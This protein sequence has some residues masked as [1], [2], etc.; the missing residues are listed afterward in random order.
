VH[1]FI[2]RAAALI[3]LMLAMLLASGFITPGTARAA[4]SFLPPVSYTKTGAS[5]I[6]AVDLDADGNLDL[7]VGDVN[8][9][10]LSLLY[11]RGDGTF[12]PPVDMLLGNSYDVALGTDH[13]FIGADVNGDGLPDLIVPH[14]ASGKVLVFLNQGARTFAPPVS[15]PVGAVPVAF[16]AADFNGDGKLDLAVSNDGPNTLSVLLN[17][18]DGTF[19]PADSYPTGSLPGGVSAAD[20]DGDGRLDLAVANIIGGTVTVYFGD[21]AGK[22]LPGGTYPA[23]GGAGH[24]VIADFD[25][26]GAL[27]IA[28]CNWQDSSVSVLLGNGNGAFKPTLYYPAGGNAGVMGYADFDGDGAPDLA[29]ARGHTDLVT[30]LHNNGAGIFDSPLQFPSGG[31]NTR[32]LAVGD[33]NNDGRPDIAAGGQD[34]YT[35]SILINNTPRPAL[36]IRGLTLSSSSAVAGC[37]VTHGVVTLT[38]PAPAGGT[39]IVL[40]SSNPAVMVPA[41]VPVPEGATQTTFTPMVSPVTTTVVGTITASLPGSVQRAPFTVRPGGMALLKLAPAALIGGGSVSGEVDLVCPAGPQGATVVL[42]SSRPDL[43]PA[44]AV[45]IVPPGGTRV[46]F[47]LPTQR[48]SAD[49]AVTLTATFDGFTRT[50]KVELHPVP[51]PPPPPPPVNLLVNGSFEDPDTSGSSIGWLTYGAAGIPGRAPAGA[52]IPG[53]KITQGTVDVTSWYWKAA[54]GR[55]S[56]DLVGDNPGAF[57]QSFATEPGKEY[58]FSGV[59]AHNPGNFFLAEGRGNVF[60]NHLFLTQLVHQDEQA[61]VSDMHW[62][63]FS[64][65]F[66]ATSATTTLT[67]SDATGTPFPGG[68]VLDGLAVTPTGG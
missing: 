51:P 30:V 39:A 54:V 26:D 36:A 11:G 21:G 29:C 38:S 14:W 32:T 61:T 67:I 1:R 65:R 3:S 16:T 68:L 47:S 17:R 23:G 25:G 43:L 40:T 64:V 66:R 59:I 13:Q 15:Y 37:D 57:E 19:Q 2:R 7:I 58:S 50:A 60:V 41:S 20:L 9:P 12:E 49:T 45:V 42:A 33:F 5:G 8:G 48:V 53:W 35:V 55:Q 62:T 24:V 10:R 56:L 18:G 6:T 52:S 46:S 44:P 27:D 4:I 22:F 63:S 28:T 31:E 34:T